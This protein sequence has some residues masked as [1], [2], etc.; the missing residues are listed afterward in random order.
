MNWTELNDPV[1][2]SSVFRCTLG[3]TRTPQ[4]IK[5]Q[6]FSNSSELLTTPCSRNNICDDISNG[7]T[8]IVLTNTPTNRHYRKQETSLRYRWRRL[9]LQLLSPGHT[10]A[11]GP[12]FHDFSHVNVAV[13]QRLLLQMPAKS[14]LINVLPPSLLT[15]CINIRCRSC[16]NLSS[17]RQGHSLP[18]EVLP[19]CH[20]SRS[21]V[22]T[23]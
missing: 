21:L 6:L 16:S 19:G 1:Q 5:M 18:N 9:L 8:V 12:L 11:G 17:F 15:S 13:V 20:Y 22:L 2:F 14:S 4:C 23:R 10:A 7:S 3:T